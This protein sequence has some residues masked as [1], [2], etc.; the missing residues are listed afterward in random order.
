MINNLFDKNVKLAGLKRSFGYD[1]YFKKYIFEG[2]DLSH[3]KVLDLGGGNG[4]AS[5]FL[6]HYSKTCEIFL[7]DPY[8]SGSNKLMKNQFLNFSSIYKKSNITHYNSL[9]ELP[10]YIKFDLILLHNSIN[11]IGEDLILNLD[12]KDKLNEYMD[13][14][15]LVLDKAKVESNIIISDCSN[16]NF[17]N[18]IGVHNF[19]APTIQWHLHKEPSFWQNIFYQLGCSHIRTKWTSRREFLSL[20][21]YVF[22]NKFLSYFINS[23]FVSI[24]QKN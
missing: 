9:E 23:H 11:H 20:G 1:F 24:Y 3:K 2:F 13:R 21:K 10:K 8:K 5:F 16:K 7:V 18:D 14:L 4:I 22:A 6:S 17:W 19:F 12:N 15:Y